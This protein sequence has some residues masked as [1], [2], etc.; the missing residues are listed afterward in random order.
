MPCRVR[1]TLPLLVCTIFLHG[2]CSHSGNG[3]GA[4]ITGGD[5][6]R[7]AVAIRRYGCDTCHVIPGV[8]GARGLVGPTLAGIGSRTYLGG[9]LANTSGNL[10]QWIRTPREI[11]P[12]TA[13][14]DT[15]VTPSDGRDIAAY[16]YTLQ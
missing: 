14:P 7:G 9:Q 11:V 4:Q 15:G 2:A 1:L 12:H 8:P 13:M 10:Q 3:I 5:P 16:L 6:H